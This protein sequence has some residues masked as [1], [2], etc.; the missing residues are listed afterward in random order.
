MIEAIL[1]DK[2][3]TLFDFQKTWGGW[4]A[5]FLKSLSEDDDDLYE[6]LSAR[7]RFD[8]KTQTFLPDSPVIAGTPD[9]GVNLILPL[10]PQWSFEDLLAHS[11]QTAAD[12]PLAEVIPLVPFLDQLARA[13]LT[14]GVATNDSEN[15]AR[16]HLSAVG[17]EDKFDRIIG[18]DSGF[19]AKPG[20]GMCLGFAEVTGASVETTLMVGD[21]LHDI[22]AG[23]DAGMVTVGVLTG[24]AAFEDLSPHAD[25][26][27]ESIAD[28]PALLG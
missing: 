5:K 27:L 21:S 25:H 24:P 6:Q 28:L 7:V 22:E 18:S 11:N 20:P 1:F 12:A 23:R 15:S 8:L 16:A 13:N 4:A 14:L 26:V 17:A 2:D 9:E 3:G 10:L 19:G